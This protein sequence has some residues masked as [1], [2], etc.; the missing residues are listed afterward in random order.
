MITCQVHSAQ[1]GVGSVRL[2][3]TPSPLLFR[4]AL[5]LILLNRPPA[6]SCPKTII[7]LHSRTVLDW[8]V[9]MDLS[10]EQTL[11]LIKLHLI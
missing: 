10:K 2:I 11:S 5:L 3:L 4:A 8:S 7:T 1:G 6:P 9:T